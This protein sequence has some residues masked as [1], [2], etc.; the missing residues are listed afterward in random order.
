MLSPLT[1]AG[2]VYRLERET[3]ERQLAEA[4]ERT[5]REVEQRVRREA[6]QE[7]RRQIEEKERAIAER[8]VELTDSVS[9][10]IL[11]TAHFLKMDL[12]NFFP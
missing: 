11:K 2:G 4:E 1:V 9:K 6:E 5:A 8:S 7:M 3:L 10:P 12:G